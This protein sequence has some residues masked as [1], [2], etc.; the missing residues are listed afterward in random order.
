MYPISSV[1]GAKS[2][3]SAIAGDPFGRLWASSTGVRALVSSAA[4]NVPG[5]TVELSSGSGSV[6]VSSNLLEKTVPPSWLM[7]P[8]SLPRVRFAQA[9]PRRETAAT[10]LRAAGTAERAK[11]FGNFPLFFL[12][13]A[14][15]LG[16]Q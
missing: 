7:S 14:S 8:L 4:L 13:P 6:I 2:T 12:E 11:V 15:R 16:V 1:T 3:A 5:P 9:Q 10:P